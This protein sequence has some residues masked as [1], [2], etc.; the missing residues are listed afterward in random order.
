MDLG[1][2]FPLLFCTIKQV[3]HPLLWVDEKNEP[4]QQKALPNT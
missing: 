4:F 2:P 3:R 1:I